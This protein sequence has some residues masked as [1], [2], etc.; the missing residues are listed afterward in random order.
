M[1]RKPGIRKGIYRHP[2]G[3]FNDSEL[4]SFLHGHHSLDVLER[5]VMGR[6]RREENSER[7]ARRQKRASRRRR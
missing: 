3:D 2:R 4:T 1:R 6:K 5:A 7:R